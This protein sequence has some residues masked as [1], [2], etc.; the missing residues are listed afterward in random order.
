MEQSANWYGIKPGTCDRCGSV[1]KVV[2][3]GRLWI[4]RGC[5]GMKLKPDEI[6]GRRLPDPEAADG[7]DHPL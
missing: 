3:D 2:I 5:R 7:R 6:V 1:A 4:C